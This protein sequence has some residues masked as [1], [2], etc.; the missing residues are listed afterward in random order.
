MTDAGAVSLAE[1]LDERQHLLDIALWMFGSAATAE[2]IVHET[3]RRWYALDDGERAG[4]AVPRAWLTRVAGGIC[5][6]LLASGTPGGTPTGAP[7]E[8]LAGIP[9]DA[10]AAA[11][12][13]TFAAAPDR[14]LAGSPESGVTGVP[15]RPAGGVVGP[16]RG[17]PGRIGDDRAMLDRHDRIARRFAA[18]CD[19]G[20]PAALR[21]IL[22]DDAM[23]VSDGGGRVRAAVRPAHGADAV[24]R[25][26]TALLARQPGTVVAAEPVNGRTGLVLRRAGRAV[27]AVSVSVAGARVT[28]VWIVLNPDKLLGWHHP[29]TAAPAAQAPRGF[30][31]ERRHR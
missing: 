27:A 16:A 1:M 30:G 21:E 7:G 29:M 12:D 20:D 14:T 31:G 9:G 2:R 18:A 22:A 19:A 15:A 8:T 23:T 13:A 6:S 3:Y 17:G 5:L 10:L 4:I 26:V 11:P 25:F 24:A 28:A